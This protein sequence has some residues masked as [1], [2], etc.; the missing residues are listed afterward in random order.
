MNWCIITWQTLAKSSTVNLSNHFLFLSP[1]L[2]LPPEQWLSIKVNLCL[3]FDKEA[4]LSFSDKCIPPSSSWGGGM[5]LLI[6]FS[7]W[8]CHCLL[9]CAHII[10]SGEVR[11]GLHQDYH[12]HCCWWSW[13]RIFL[14][15]VKSSCDCDEWVVSWQVVGRWQE[16]RLSV[17]ECTNEHGL[18]LHCSGYILEG[19]KVNESC[20]LSTRVT[21]PWVVMSTS[22]LPNATAS[23]VIIGISFRC[24]VVGQ[25]CREKE[26]KGGS[27]Q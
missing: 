18:V 25:I 6:Q 20:V 22:F 23:S 12:V 27:P 5:Y 9:L 26:N 10:F 15:N 8:P 16:N 17:H 13:F 7:R 2:P 1:H 14:N 4:G 11:Y 24:A 19:V 3:L 21:Q